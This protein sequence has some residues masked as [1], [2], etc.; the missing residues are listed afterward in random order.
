MVTLAKRNAGIQSSHQQ[1]I[2]AQSSLSDDRKVI[3]SPALRLARNVAANYKTM[4]KSILLLFLLISLNSFSQNPSGKYIRSENEYLDFF[5]NNKVSFLLERDGCLGKEKLVGDGIYKI[6]NDVII[7]DIES[8]KKEFESTFAQ[9]QDTNNENK[10]EVTVN[11]KDT[12]SNP[13]PSVSISFI[14]NSNKINGTITDENGLAFVN[15][16]EVGGSELIVSFVGYTN[17]NIPISEIKYSEIEVVL[18]DG[19]TIF[20]DGRKI[21]IKFKLNKAEK[22]FE[23]EI[24]KI[25]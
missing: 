11:I 7:I 17:A 6:K 16:S 8:H 22:K 21:K 9:I 20:L 1:R 25:K 15:L 12:N 14:D 5:S 19:N 10:N 4:K 24:L 13:I 3:R 2:F 18:K 23:A